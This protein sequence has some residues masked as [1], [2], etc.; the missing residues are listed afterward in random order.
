[1]GKQCGAG[2]KRAALKLAKAHAASVSAITE[3][4]KGHRE[5]KRRCIISRLRVLKAPA[6][7]W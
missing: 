3:P 6:V 7:L 1:M 4:Q 2:G 5:A